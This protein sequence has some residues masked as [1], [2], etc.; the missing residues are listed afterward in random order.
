MWY[1]LNICSLYISSFIH[2]GFSANCTSDLM[3]TVLTMNVV[4]A[5][6]VSSKR[7]I[8]PKY[9][10]LG[11]IS[12]YFLNMYTKK[13]LFNA[14]TNNLIN[15]QLLNL[16]IFHSTFQKASAQSPRSPFFP[17]LPQSTSG[18]SLVTS[19]QKGGWAEIPY[20]LS[21]HRLSNSHGHVTVLIEEG[22][23]GG[24]RRK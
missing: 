10:Y 16:D 14:N 7:N 18:P 22:G 6:R 21:F 2:F 4:E 8:F 20:W 11:N 15:S 5:I 13:K 17:S 19:L 24:R 23:G 3:K 12:K 1:L 9:F